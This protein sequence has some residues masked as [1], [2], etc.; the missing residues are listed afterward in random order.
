MKNETATPTNHTPDELV[1]QIDRL[2]TEA[3]ALLV[4][5]AAEAAN[6]RF[7]ALRPRLARLQAKASDLY[8]GARRRVTTG[9]KAT[10]DAI[11]THPYESLAIT[12][13]LGV[14]LGTLLRRSR[15]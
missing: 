5:P 4:G 12:L 3:E 15:D 6:D 2:M 10:D 8:A 9:A 13:G 1:S 7:A 14:L 11:R